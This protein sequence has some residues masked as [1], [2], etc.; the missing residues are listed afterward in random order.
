MYKELLEMSPD[1]EKIISN[2]SLITFQKG[3]FDKAL[4][5]CTKV[6]KI[7]KSLK[8]KINFK[9]YDSSF[10]VIFHLHR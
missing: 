3:E 4:N 5:H 8:E 1:N 2:L 6:L 7:I 10:E 9:K